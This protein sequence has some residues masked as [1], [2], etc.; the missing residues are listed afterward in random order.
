MSD[1]IHVGTESVT[2]WK[3]PLREREVATMF[4][5]AGWTKARRALGA[6]RKDDVGDIDGVP[7][8]CI[9]VAGRKTGLAAVIKEKLPASELQRRN[10]GVPFTSLF[11]RMDRNPWLVFLSPSQFFTLF[12]YALIGYDVERLREAANLDPNDD[13]VPGT[14]A[15]I[16]PN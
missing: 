4:Q 11:I 10:R 13:H 14:G 5:E 12:R 7:N 16:R 1:W 2:H 9:Q 6:G 3:G 15:D 8:L